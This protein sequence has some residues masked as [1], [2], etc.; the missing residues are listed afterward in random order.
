[1]LLATFAEIMI[2]GIRI[3]RLL[4]RIALLFDIYLHEHLERTIA[5][6]QI[7]DLLKC[8]FLSDNQQYKERAWDLHFLSR[9]SEPLC[10]L[11]IYFNFANNQIPV[12]T[13]SKGVGNMKI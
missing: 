1:M 2:V 6:T 8:I 3:A 5:E 11:T 10:L 12:L 7:R 4:E 13:A 9:K